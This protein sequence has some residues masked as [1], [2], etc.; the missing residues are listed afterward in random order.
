MIYW[1]VS[2]VTA[3]WKCCFSA[4]Y[5]S[6]QKQR[7]VTLHRP[8]ASSPGQ[9]WRHLTNERKLFSKKL[10]CLSVCTGYGKKAA[11]RV[12]KLLHIVQKSRSS[13][14]SWWQRVVDIEA[15]R[16]WECRQFSSTQN[17]PSKMRRDRFSTSLSFRDGFNFRPQKNKTI[18]EDN[19]SNKKK[20]C[21]QIY[22]GGHNY[23]W[24]AHPGKVYVWETLS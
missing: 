5:C 21:H 7:E 16:L 15:A 18:K 17:E 19:N 2:W 9:Y 22:L 11:T 14:R 13:H 23:T 6:E 3:N 12:W 24:A 1:W 8:H 4:V 10:L 20:M